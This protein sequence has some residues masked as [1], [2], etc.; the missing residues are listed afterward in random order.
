MY[1]PVKKDTSYNVYRGT[2]AFIDAPGLV[3]GNSIG[4]PNAPFRC[5]PN[6]CAIAG[7]YGWSP[8]A[9]SMSPAPL[10]AAHGNMDFSVR[11]VASN[12][13][14]AGV[15]K[16][17]LPPVT[18]ALFGC[19]SNPTES[20]FVGGAGAS[21]AIGFKTFSIYGPGGSCCAI[22][23]SPASTAWARWSAG[24]SPAEPPTPCH[25][26]RRVGGLEAA[27][28]SGHYHSYGR[29]ANPDGSGHGR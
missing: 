3:E 7:V 28:A 27:C 11:A 18:V 1:V 21:Y 26:R 17:S 23:A 13:E 29:T 24:F 19:G 25:G 15:V 9:K 6:M 20:Y 16:C 2:S 8:P 22:S 4:R 14:Y 12:G 5:D 10:D